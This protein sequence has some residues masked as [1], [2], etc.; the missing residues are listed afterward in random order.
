MLVGTS[1]NLSRKVPEGQYLLKKNKIEVKGDKID[2]AKV[3]EVIRQSPN[4]SVLGMKMRLWA[5]NQDHFLFMKTD[6]LTIAKLVEKKRTKRKKINEKRLARQDRINEKRIAK[7]RKRGQDFY[8]EKI[9]PLK[10]TTKDSGF[11]R[12]WFKYGFGEPPVIVDSNATI[13]TISSINN[14]MMKKGYF[15]SE[16]DYKL[17]TNQRK[18]NISITYQ[19]KTHSPYIIDSVKSY[20]DNQELKAIFPKFLSQNYD[21]KLRKQRLDSDVL[22]NTKTRIANFFRN[23]GFYGFVPNNI[24]I[25]V[26]TTLG[27]HKAFVAFYFNKRK[28]NENGVIVEKEQS[29]KKVNHV[30]FH[31]A[32]TINVT[33]DYLT[34]LNERGFNL[35]KEKFLPTLDTVYF[36]KIR[37]NRRQR[38]ALNIT[39]KDSLNPGRMAYVSYNKKLLVRPVVLES[40]NMLEEGSDYKEYIFKNSVNRLANI[41]VFQVVKPEIIELPDTNLID[42]HYYLVPFKKQSFSIEPRFTN[43]NGFLG[44][45]A[46]LSYTNRNLFH[47]GENLTISFSGGL[48]SNPPVFGGTNIDGTTDVVY[49]RTFNT[50][51]FGPSIKLEIPNLLPFPFKVVPKRLGPITTISLSY[52]NQH[53]S[54][55]TR[56]A[57]QLDY[58]YKFTV[59]YGQALSIG[60]PFASVIKYVNINKS[61]FFEQKLQETGDLFLRNAYSNQLIWEDVKI[62][63]ETSNFGSYIHSPI[64]YLYKITFDHAGI[65]PMI[66]NNG[67][68][69]ET[70]QR[71]IFGVTYSQFARLDNEIIGEYTINKKSSFNFRALIGAGLPYRNITTSLPYDYSFYAGGANDNRGWAA[72]TLGPGSYKYYLDENRTI[73]Q[74]GDIRLGVQ[75]EYR[76]AITNLFKV[77]AFIDANNIWTLNEDVNRPG[78]Q[79]SKDFYREIAL[80]PGVGLRLDFSFFVFRLD[81]GVPFTNPALPKGSRWIFQSRQPYYDEGFAKFGADY[82]NR[83]PKPFMPALQFGIGYPF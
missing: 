24:S 1:C 58:L 40:R 4:R 67:Y 65:I 42:V 28:V 43:S 62:V 79:I 61:A 59:K 60:L 18:R 38:K 74:I 34:T 11:F 37:Y 64:K 57:V 77:A 78:S 66:F 6:S 52:N 31:L 19:I 7:A 70:G 17:D 14:Y 29:K 47:G 44:F 48:E 9:I 68:N 16:I 12:Y 30:Y 80:S 55:F 26:D 51:E 20:A 53:R 13:R 35:N 27:N 83:L 69:N 39:Q 50:Y 25:E 46:S 36:Q 21:I 63:Y 76:F 5:Y 73:T 71:T 23:Q 45:N 15:E 22:E 3:E 41:N 32:D 33:S 81:L 72:R 56:E 10:D 82:K 8:Y 2:K 49:K 54:D 75:L